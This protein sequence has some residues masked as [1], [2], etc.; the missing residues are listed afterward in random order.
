MVVVSYRS[1]A[2]MANDCSQS[3]QAMA[4]VSSTAIASNGC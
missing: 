4:V 2:H 1:D 3:A